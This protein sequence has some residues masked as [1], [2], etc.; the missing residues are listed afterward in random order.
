LHKKGSYLLSKGIKY[1]RNI[2]FRIESRYRWVIIR[3]LNFEMYQKT[4]V[5]AK[6]MVI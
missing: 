1:A 6:N 3:K 5:N 4:I 2:Y